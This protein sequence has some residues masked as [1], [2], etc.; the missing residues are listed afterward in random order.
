M[1][2]TGAVLVN[3][4]SAV[5][6]SRVFVEAARCGTVIIFCENFKPA[7]LMLPAN[8]ATDTH[9][10]RAQLGLSPAM[11]RTLW[12]KTVSAKCANQ[13]ALAARLAPELPQTRRLQRAAGASRPDKESGCARL[14]WSAVSRHLGMERFLRDRRLSGMNSLLNYGYAVLLA[15]ILQRLA[16]VGIDPVCGISHVIRERAAPLAYDLME[17]FRVAVDARVFDWVKRVHEGSG[18]A[19]D[20]A[21]VVSPEFKRWVQAFTGAQAPYCG[22]SLTMDHLIVQVLR[23]FR[24]AVL[25]RRPGNYAPWTLKDSKWDGCS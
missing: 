14:Y 15:R 12:M 22:K 5:V 16:A 3:S 19:G 18:G 13:A 6:H 9:L 8:R 2:D 24:E 20:S 7:S 21:L 1:E 25:G 10:T 4:F 23:G 11:R 17:P